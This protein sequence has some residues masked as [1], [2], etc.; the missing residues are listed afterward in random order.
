[1]SKATE[2]RERLRAV[3][4]VRKGFGR[5][6]IKTLS[7]GTISGIELRA[8]QLERF[9]GVNC[10]VEA[11]WVEFGNPVVADRVRMIWISAGFPVTPCKPRADRCVTLP[12]PLI[13]FIEG[14]IPGG[15][16]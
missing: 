11:A 7:A 13:E 10:K 4:Q 12:A 2:Y 8:A 3:N 14:R 16:Q 1:L 15:S 9:M 5:P 6:S